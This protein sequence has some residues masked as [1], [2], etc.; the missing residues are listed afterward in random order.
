[1]SGEDPYLYRGAAVLRNR[2]GIRDAGKLDEIERRMVTQRASEGSPTGRFDLDHLRT[3]H[4]HLFQDV[5]DWA[6][7]LRT[8]EIWKG[9]QQFQ[10]RQFIETGMAG[11]H[12]RLVKAGFLRNLERSSF[13]EAAGQIMGDVN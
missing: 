12:R 3:I 5:F 8:V 9:G 7:E 1:V 6:G 2:L 4:R 11:V 10:F 13:A